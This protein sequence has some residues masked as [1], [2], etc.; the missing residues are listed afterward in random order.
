MCVFFVSLL[1]CAVISI[2]K[3]TIQTFL[4]TVDGLRFFSLP[5]YEG[6]S[7]VSHV[8]TLRNQ[9]FTI[10]SLDTLLCKQN[11]IRLVNIVGILWS[12]NHFVSFSESLSGRHCTLFGEKTQRIN[13]LVYENERLSKIK[14]TPKVVVSGVVRKNKIFT[15]WRFKILVSWG[16]NPVVCLVKMSK[17][18][19]RHRSEFSRKYFLLESRS[20]LKR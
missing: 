7:E 9:R 3:P 15:E 10:G 2:S 6:N 19:H 14:T 16:P 17:S 12:R 1:W 18:L 13:N 5:L 4:K 8:G 11:K 20:L